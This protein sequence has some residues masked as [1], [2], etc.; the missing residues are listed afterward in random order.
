[1]FNLLDQ[2]PLSNGPYI[3][4]SMRPTFVGSN[5]GAFGMVIW[6]CRERILCWIIVGILS[7]F[8]HKITQQKS[9]V[10]ACVLW[11]ISPLKVFESILFFCM[12]KCLVLQP[13]GPHFLTFLHSYIYQTSCSMNVG[14]NAAGSTNIFIQQYTKLTN[15]WSDK[16]RVDIGSMLGPFDKCSILL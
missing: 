9:W 4:P 3:S 5:V 14:R 10:S 13:S 6:Q 11:R 2:N 1:M 8:F 7:C 12:N 15:I 16:C